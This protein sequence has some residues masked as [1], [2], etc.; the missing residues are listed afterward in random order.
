LTRPLK[1]LRQDLIVDHIALALRSPGQPA[2]LL[3]G[4]QAS[5]KTSVLHAVEDTLASDFRAR[6]AIGDSIERDVSEHVFIGRVERL[7]KRELGDIAFDAA[8]DVRRFLDHEGVPFG[9]LI[10]RTLAYMTSG[11]PTQ[12]VSDVQ[13][14][15]LSRLLNTMGFKRPLLICDD[16]HYWDRSSLLFLRRILRG[17]LAR[18]YK[19]LSTTPILLALDRSRV[20]QANEE[21]VSDI[22]KWSPEASA[23]RLQR[24]TLRQYAS[25]LRELGLK[26][27]LGATNVEELFSLTGGNLALTKSIVTYVERGGSLAPDVSGRAPEVRNLFEKL[28]GT[29]GQE[30]SQ[31]RM[32]VSAVVASGRELD[33]NLLACLL[34]LSR[35]EAEDL[36]NQAA[37]LLSFIS[38]SGIPRN[39]A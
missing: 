4:P 17:D 31:I 39:R 24:P 11:L 38:V 25:V 29:R 20:S 30:G 32:V 6:Y 16:L 22:L 35:Q 13:Q 14:K 27:S 5:G 33:L 18:S 19:R 8:E 28:L 34:D 10:H 15:F 21:V 1:S 37:S 26:I 36:A 3:E 2:V 12:N 23:F 9:R 7:S